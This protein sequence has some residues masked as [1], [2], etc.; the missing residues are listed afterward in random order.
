MKKTLTA[1]LFICL[2]A[3]LA[4]GGASY[5]VGGQ[6]Q[7]QHDLLI[8]QINRVNYLDISSKSYQRGIFSS[9]ASTN[10]TVTPR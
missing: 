5:W 3:A 1:L 2:A 7:K 4:Y 6:A 10:V 9:T 8:A